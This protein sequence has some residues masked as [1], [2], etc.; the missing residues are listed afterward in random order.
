MNI[1][2]KTKTGTNFA[3]LRLLVVKTLNAVD[4]DEYGNSSNK[5]SEKFDRESQ[6]RAILDKEKVVVL[7]ML[8]KLFLLLLFSLCNCDSKRR[9]RK[10][11]RCRV[12]SFKSFKSFRVLQT[13]LLFGDEMVRYSKVYGEKKSEK[14][15]NESISGIHQTLCNRLDEDTMSTLLRE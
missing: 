13:R 5:V 6:C 3:H 10:M 2:Q 14:Y 1:P 15:C 7:F 9:S 4:L 8:L 12:H 11:N